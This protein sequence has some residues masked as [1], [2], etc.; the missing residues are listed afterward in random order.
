MLCRGYFFPLA[1][2]C[3]VGVQARCVVHP[4]LDSQLCWKQMQL[5]TSI[6]LMKC[7]GFVEKSRSL[8]RSFDLLTVWCM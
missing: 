2:V 1:W 3:R 4:H 7:D 5:L 6:V 8:L